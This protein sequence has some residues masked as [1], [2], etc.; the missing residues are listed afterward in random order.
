MDARNLESGGTLWRML[1]LRQ[2]QK[3]TLAELG[4]SMSL[5]FNHGQ[6]MTT[7]TRSRCRAFV[8][9]GHSVKNGAVSVG[10][11]RTRRIQTA[12]LTIRLA[13]KKV[14]REKLDSGT[15]NRLGETS[16]PA[17]IKIRRNT[18]GTITPERIFVGSAN[19]IKRMLKPKRRP[20]TAQKKPQRRR[21]S[22]AYPPAVRFAG[23]PRGRQRTTILTTRPRLP[24]LA[25]GECFPLFLEAPRFLDSHGWN[26]TPTRCS[27]GLLITWHRNAADSKKWLR[28]RGSQQG[29][30]ARNWQP[31]IIPRIRLP[32][33]D[34]RTVP[35]KG[36]GPGTWAAVPQYGGAG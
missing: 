21:S 24:R 26:H 32:F 6:S 1:P 10:I 16:R 18:W 3:P 19:V 8:I 30:N 4:I 20:F 35:S 5:S 13:Q 17:N 34:A 15:I 28:C 11:V 2:R 27:T 22:P 33:R 36:R 12:A 9:G 23:R 29:Q 31:P 25:R 14:P 7:E